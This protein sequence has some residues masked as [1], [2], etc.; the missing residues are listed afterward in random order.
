MAGLEIVIMLG[1]VRVEMSA[2]GGFGV[3]GGSC[4]FVTGLAVTTG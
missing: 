2:W 3:V 1:V 4:M